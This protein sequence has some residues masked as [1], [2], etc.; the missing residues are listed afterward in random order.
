MGSRFQYHIHRSSGSLLGA[1]IK[2]FWQLGWEDLDRGWLDL[3]SLS[4]VS[5]G[6]KR[7]T[8]VLARLFSLSQRQNLSFRSSRLLFGHPKY[9]LSCRGP[10]KHHFQVIRK[11][12]YPCRA[13]GCHTR[14]H[15]YLK[16]RGDGDRKKLYV[17]LVS[18]VTGNNDRTFSQTKHH[19]D[20]SS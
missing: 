18:I 19:S 2:Y 20:S 6:S 3:G 17:T 7:G 5:V 13:Q 1:G 15:P 8:L 10:P 11:P 14:G 12:F 9:S 4:Q 16:K